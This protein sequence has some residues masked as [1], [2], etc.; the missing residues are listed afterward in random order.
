MTVSELPKT[1]DPKSAE[2]K[3]YPRWEAAKDLYIA[4]PNKAAERFTIM[5]PPPNV[6]GS[7]HMGHALN[8]TLHDILIRMNRMQ[9]KDVL[10]LPGTD[11]ASIAV[12]MVLERQ[13][14][15][16]GKTKHDLGRKKFLERAWEWKAESGSTI[17]GQL[18][19]IGALP[20]WSR[21]RFT[22]DDGLSNAVTHAFIK[23]YRDGLIYRDKRLTN[24][25]PKMQTSVSDIEVQQ[26]E[27]KGHLWHIRYPIKGSDDRFITIATT[28]PETMLGDSAIVVHP[29]DERYRDMIG[30]VAVLPLVGRELKIVADEYVDPTMGTGAMKVTPAHDFNDYALGKQHGF[31]QITVLDLHGRVV[32][33]GVPAEYAG[34]DRFDARKKVVADL[35][36]QGF[37]VE[38][39]PHTHNVPHSERGGVPVEPMLTDQ[40]YIKMDDLAARAI[41]A[42]ENGETRFVPKNWEN[43]FFEWLRNIQPWC[44][45]RQLWWGHQIPAWYDEEGNI[46]VA[47]TEAEAVAQSGGKNLRR[48]EDIFD[49]WFSAGLWPFS[50]LGWPEQTQD[51]QTYYPGNVLITGFDIIFFWVARMMMLGLYFMDEV[52][53][54]DVYIHALVRDATGAK[55]SKSKG[56][57]IDPLSLIDDYGA[58]ALRF[59]LTAM[60]AQ[61]RDIKLSE[62]RVE[63]YR[64]FTTKLWNSARFAQINGCVYDP[65]FDPVSTREPVNQWIIDSLATTAKTVTAALAEYKFNDAAN[66]LYQFIWHQFCDWYVE[67]SKPL[68]QTEGHSAQLETRGTVMWVLEQALHL[69]HPIMPYVTEELWNQLFDSSSL[70]AT[71]KWPELPETLHQPSAREKIDTI[72]AVISNIRAARQAL[73]VPAS[74][75]IPIRVIGASDTLI[76]ELEVAFPMIARLARVEKIHFSTTT[77]PQKGEAQITLP[78]CLLLLPLDG[79]IDFAVESARLAKQAERIAKEIAGLEARL[80]NDDFV[81]GA[82]EEI[83]EEQREKLFAAQNNYQK[84]TAA[85]AQIS[86][87]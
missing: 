86:V 27:V 28:R 70:L 77:S 59:T 1:Y 72:I 83:I 73:N 82:P 12:H 21:E 61:G 22:M 42:V 40:W 50:T 38:T 33:D 20:D 76:H 9:G 41:A 4:N 8:A 80:A 54:K 36:A 78:G 31:E 10:W 56:N 60:A 69:L 75:Q 25:D 3:H 13:L 6:T 66:A 55:M 7:L 49:T 46:F 43:T 81:S 63:G 62:Q 39:V 68:L 52:P 65:S 53:F 85:L 35:E 74:A 47:E 87:K 79:L 26:R 17:T 19:R 23:M 29:D 44:I 16:Q 64:N 67:L 14:A 48:D 37:L 71:R 34:L 18:R 2:S 58:D 57:V 24:W 32:K 11:H 30:K 15:E 5:M 84:L 45:S 51:L